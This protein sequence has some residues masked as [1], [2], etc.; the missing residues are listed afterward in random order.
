[1]RDLI[2]AA[3]LITVLI[4]GWLFFDSYSENSVSE[5]T[6]LLRDRLIPA[7][8]EERWDESADMAGRLSEN[9]HEYY[10]R[11]LFFLSSE[12]LS[13]IDQCLAKAQK[14]IQA[15]DVSNSSGELN[16]LAEILSFLTDREKIT[17]ENIF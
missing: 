11:A 8:E 16:T 14:Y 17:W 2:V 1:M 3:A 12:E 4:G 7:V 10:G 15:E 13:E 5:M 9:W 6:A